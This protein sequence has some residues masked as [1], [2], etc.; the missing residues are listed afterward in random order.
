[1][2]ALDLVPSVWNIIRSAPNLRTVYVLLGT[3]ESDVGTFYELDKIQERWII[4][5]PFS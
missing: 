5:R 1:M 2:P 4:K 3:I